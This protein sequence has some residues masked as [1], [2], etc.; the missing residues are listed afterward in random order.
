MGWTS[1]SGAHTTRD[2]QRGGGEGGLGGSH[3]SEAEVAAP[4]GIGALRGQLL[5]L[6]QERKG[7]FAHEL[8]ANHVVIDAIDVQR[9]VHSDLAG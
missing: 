8:I 3:I 7:E 5:Q 6:L 1:T 4:G 9:L 2:A